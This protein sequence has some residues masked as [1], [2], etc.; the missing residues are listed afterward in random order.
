PSISPS[1]IAKMLGSRDP[2]EREL[3]P[4][5]IKEVV[6]AVGI[7]TMMWRDQEVDVRYVGSVVP[8]DVLPAHVM[9]VATEDDPLVAD[10]PKQHVGSVVVVVTVDSVLDDLLGR[11]EYIQTVPAR[12]IAL[13]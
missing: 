6:G 11:C 12:L 3:R 4:E 13:I 9:R 8:E 10:Q 2:E 5:H 7:S 1:G